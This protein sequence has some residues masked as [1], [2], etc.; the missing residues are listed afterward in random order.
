MPS[1]P[2]VAT[3]V[4]EVGGRDHRSGRIGGAGEQHALQRLFGVRRRA[5]ARPSRWPAPTELDLDDF[6]AERGHDVAVGRIAGRGD[7]DTVAGIEHRQKCQVE[8]RR[9]AGRHR[10]PLPAGPQRRS[11]RDSARRS[12]RAG[13]QARARRCSRC[14]HRASARA[15]ASR[16]ARGAGSEG[17]PTAIEID[18]M[19]EAFS[20]LA[21]AS[22]SIAWNG[23]TSPRREIDSAMSHDCSRRRVS[24]R[25]APHKCPNDV[26]IT[27]S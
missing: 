3:S 10:D 22:T 27:S 17:C 7:R 18:R 25:G 12:P 6:D 4:F 15:A 13:R 5:D 24:Q 26:G 2:A 9:R 1:S 21:S 8:G 19:A 16:T 23:S 20:R 14:G 11:A